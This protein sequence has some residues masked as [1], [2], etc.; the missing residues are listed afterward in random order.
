MPYTKKFDKTLYDPR[1]LRHMYVSKN[2]T[3]PEIAE[4]LGCTIGAVL[5]N[6]RRHKIPLEPRKRVRQSGSHAPRPRTRFLTTLHNPEWLREHY[7]EKKLNASQLAH[8]TGAS[9]PATLRALRVAGIRVRSIGEVKRC[10][11]NPKRRIHDPT[12]VACRHRA[13]KKTPPGPCVLCSKTGDAVNHKDRNPFN[14][15]EENLERLCNQCHSR[16]H[17]KELRVM[18][19]WLRDRFGVQYIDIHLEARRRLTQERST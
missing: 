3:P 1:W 11:P 2:M 17:A 5:D 18:I 12:E 19:E 16:Q 8:L 13:R 14:E 9:I 10:K 7:E 6:L 15:S 4:H